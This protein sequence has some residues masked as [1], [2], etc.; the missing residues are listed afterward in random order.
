MKKIYEKPDVE[1]VTFDVHEVITLGLGEGEV[2][3]SIGA[4]P[5]ALDDE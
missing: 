3:N 4:N 1:Y 5:F 2:D